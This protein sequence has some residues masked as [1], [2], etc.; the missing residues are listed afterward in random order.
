M[1]RMGQPKY[2]LGDAADK[3]YT[4]ALV[5]LG[6]REYCAAQLRQKLLGRGAD[7]R[8]TETVLARLKEQGDLDDARYAGAYVRD[9]REFRPCG[10]SLMRRE[11]R[12]RD[13]EPAIIEVALA[14]EYDGDKEKEALRRLIEKAATEAPAA[15]DAAA[16]KRYRE[17]IVRRLLSKGF[18]LGEIL[19]QLDDF[20]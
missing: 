11:L 6:R 4:A 3:I 9:R 19:G 5:Y 1:A 12:A 15:A 7:P 20:E 18:S 16:R 2:D 8:Q 10:A 17:K 13:I 14:E